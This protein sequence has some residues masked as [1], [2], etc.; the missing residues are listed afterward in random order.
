MCQSNLGDMRFRSEQINS[1][2]VR[3]WVFWRRGSAEEGCTGAR[4][5]EAWQR[6]LLVREEKNPVTQTEFAF[7]WSSGESQRG[8]W[9]VT[10]W[11]WSQATSYVSSRSSIFIPETV[12]NPCKRLTRGQKCLFHTLYCQK[13]PRVGLRTCTSNTDFSL[14]ILWTLGDTHQEEI[15]QSSLILLMYT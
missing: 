10:P 8:R 15:T 11:A 7:W 1:A 12:A 13:L 9:L 5:R 2:V 14:Q 4:S 6:S 3:Q